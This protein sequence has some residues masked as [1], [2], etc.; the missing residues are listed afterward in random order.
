MG[1][2]QAI[3]YPADAAELCEIVAQAVA[4][5]RALE[6]RSGG[7]KRDIG[8]PGRET[9]LVDLRALSGVVDYEPSE[10]VLTVRP[11]TPLAEVEALLATHGQMLAFEP[12]DHGPLFG[13]S[14]GAATIG[15]IVAA[16]VAG[17]RRVSAGGARDH[18]LGFAAVSGRAERFKGGGKVV[19]NVTGYD[20]SKV[21]TGSW[22]QLAVMTELTLKV[23]PRPRATAT[24]VLAGLTPSAAIA[25]MAK[26]FGSPTSPAAAAYRPSSNERASLTAIRVEGFAESVAARTDQLTAAL[27]DFAPV[28]YLPEGH[29]DQLWT[30]FRE[31]GPLGTCSALWRIHV[32]PSRA[33]NLLEALEAGGAACLCDWAGAL[34]WAGAASD[35]DIRRIAEDG[36][37]HAMLVRGAVDLRGRHP[38]RQP[39]PPAVAALATRLKLAFD[40]AGILD[41]YRF[42]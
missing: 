9:S 4:E 42:G 38:I 12:W 3:L 23:L 13:R 17:P 6:A 22:G 1:E 19:K 15:G 32:A 21:M 20:V 5:G 10:L 41:P 14:A 37:A 16:G 29:A 2:Q 28:E 35:A 39:E 24:L 11:A 30:E 26:A 33:P 36:G 8:R 7:S 25:A 31:A 34:I 40:P 18:L 27:A